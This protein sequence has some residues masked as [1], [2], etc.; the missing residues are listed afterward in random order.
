MK[1]IC[2]GCGAVSSAEAMTSDEA[3]RKTL[4]VIC[5][6]T[7]PLPPI[8]LPYLSLFRP[9]KSSLS[10]GKALRLAKELSELIGKGYAQIEKKPARKCPARLWA[11]AMEEM[12]DRRQRLTRPLKNHNYLRDVAYTL[13]DKEDAETEKKTL[14][15][16]RGGNL[17]TRP[18][19]DPHPPSR[20]GYNEQLTFDGVSPEILARLPQKVKDKYGVK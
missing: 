15:A 2:P 17:V 7:P 13:A 1:L 12:I 11:V 6:M 3:C 20:G 19:G 14:A 4:A 16:E 9:E 5:Q 18:D 8:V 10:W